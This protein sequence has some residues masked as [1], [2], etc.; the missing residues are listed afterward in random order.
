MTEGSEVK[1]FVH[2]DPLLALEACFKHFSSKGQ[3]DG[4]LILT[5][6]CST[7]TDMETEELRKELRCKCKHKKE[8]LP[9]IAFALLLQE[10][11]RDE[12]LFHLENFTSGKERIKL[13]MTNPKPKQD[14]VTDKYLAKGYEAEKVIICNLGYEK[15]HLSRA[16]IYGVEV[17]YDEKTLVNYGFNWIQNNPNHKCGQ[18]PKLKSDDNLLNYRGLSRSE[19]LPDKQN[20]SNEDS[21]PIFACLEDQCKYDAEL[22]HANLTQSSI[23][24]SILDDLKSWNIFRKRKVRWSFKTI[25]S[26]DW[27]KSMER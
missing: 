14:L 9:R 24:K 6:F 13:H 3:D 23:L 17:E 2:E 10:L 4:V 7:V 16:S 1:K 12:P 25:K 8:I 15:E 22:K 18:L 19:T 26:S 11:G 27:V 21:N 20:Y 5:Y